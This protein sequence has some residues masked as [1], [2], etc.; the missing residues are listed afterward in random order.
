MLKTPLLD[1]IFIAASTFMTGKLYF[2]QNSKILKEYVSKL[3]S[4]NETLKC[5]YSF[6]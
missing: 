2:L 4:P 6:V 3:N 1:N 5:W